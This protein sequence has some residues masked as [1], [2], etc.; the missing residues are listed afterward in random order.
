MW[1][2]RTIQNGLPYVMSRCAANHRMVEGMQKVITVERPK[3]AIIPGREMHHSRGADGL[4][5]I[6]I[7]FLKGFNAS[8]KGLS[9]GHR[10]L[11]ISVAQVRASC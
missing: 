8:F 10:C 1:I 7:G 2:N 11:H 3:M 5:Q 6:T 4:N 9:A